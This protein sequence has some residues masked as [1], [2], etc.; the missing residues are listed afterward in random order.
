[1]SFGI[2]NARLSWW[3]IFCVALITLHY[4]ERC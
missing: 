3:V 4:I 2:K 1:M